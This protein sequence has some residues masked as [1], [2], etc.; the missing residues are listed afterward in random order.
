MM[1]RWRWE[2]RGRKKEEEHERM[3]KGNVL[4]ETA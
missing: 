2:K 4:A 1:K 3:G